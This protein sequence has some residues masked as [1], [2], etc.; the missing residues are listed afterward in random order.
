MKVSDLYCG[1][2]RP[3][4]TERLCAALGI[5]GRVAAIAQVE[6]A[7]CEFR[8]P[9]EL[10]RVLRACGRL[11]TLKLDW[12]FWAQDT[13]D[14]WGARIYNRSRGRPPPSAVATRETGGKE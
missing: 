14:S 12:I 8:C 7:D 6:M 4:D 11:D 13:A 5:A 2:A 9:G 10:R 1:D 3:E